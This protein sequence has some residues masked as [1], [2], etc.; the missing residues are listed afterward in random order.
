MTCVNQIFTN[1][2]IHYENVHGWDPNVSGDITRQLMVC[3]FNI[4]YFIVVF[5]FLI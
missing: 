4:P 1:F 5:I 3:L 2:L